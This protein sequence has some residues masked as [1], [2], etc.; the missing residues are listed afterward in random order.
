MFKVEVEKGVELLLDKTIPNSMIIEVDLLQARDKILAK[1]IIASTPVPNF[2]KS[3]MDG[4]AVS[5]ADIIDASPNNPISLRVIGEICAGDVLNISYKSKTAVRVMTGGFVPDG[6]DCVIKQEDTDFEILNKQFDLETK[7]SGYEVQIFKEMHTFDNY[8]QIGEDIQKGTKMIERYKRLTSYDI[9]LLASLGFDKVPVYRPMRIGIISTGNE[10]TSL[11]EPLQA[12]QIYNSSAYAIAAQIQTVGFDVAFMHICRDEIDLLKTYIE[13]RMPEI[14]LLITTGA[15]SVGKRDIIPDTMQ[16]LGAEC[17]FQRVRMKPGTPIIAS[18][19]DNK[20]I[21]S[22]SGNPFAA[23][24]NF[25][26]FFWPIA[27][28]FMHNTSYYLKT[29]QALI[30][31][32]E[33]KSSNMRRFVRAYVDDDGVHLYT[34]KHS[35]SV[36]SNLVHSNCFIEQPANQYLQKN[37]LVTVHYWST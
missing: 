36:I 22:L 5:S 24:I 34:K 6:Y 10:L 14:D 18:T 29:K 33:L 26:M 25:N 21:L 35:S 32:G 3:G 19:Y 1:D 28:K 8:C 27:V 15:V 16:A 30:Y 31:Q 37:D 17:I 20:I 13:T 12:N 7:T 9:G 2:P 23:M 11:G 4:Y